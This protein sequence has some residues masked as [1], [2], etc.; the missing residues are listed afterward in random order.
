MKRYLP[1][2]QFGPSKYAGL[3][4]L[5]ALEQD[6][7]DTGGRSF[8]S[9]VRELIREAGEEGRDLAR[10][11][12]P[13]KTGKGA[14]SIDYHLS[15][16]GMTVEIMPDLTRYPYMYYQEVG[17]KGPYTIR[18]RNAK[19][20]KFAVGDKTVFAKQVTHPGLEAQRYMA[21]AGEEI[22]ADLQEKI[23]DQAEIFVVNDPR[24]GRKRGKQKYAPQKGKME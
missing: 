14:Q 19:A 2:P 8:D 17:T 16:D 10:K 20:L 22:V 3:A 6:I 1:Q 15:N 13:K 21:R 7:A 4:E 23:A 12:A 18:A 11:Y 24:M 9:M 5:R